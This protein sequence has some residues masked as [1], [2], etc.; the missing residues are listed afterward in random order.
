MENITREYFESKVTIIKDENQKEWF[1]GI[2]VA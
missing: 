2:D 1:K